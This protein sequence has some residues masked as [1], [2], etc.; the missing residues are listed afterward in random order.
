[1]KPGFPL[2]CR[3]LRTYFVNSRIGDDALVKNEGSR[4]GQIRCSVCDSFFMADTTPQKGLKEEL[5]QAIKEMDAR[6]ASF[7]EAEVFDKLRSVLGNKQ[8]S[9]EE[10]AVYQGE[11]DAFIFSPRR[12]DDA[13][14]PGYFQPLMWVP[15][16]DGSTI[17]SPDPAKLTSSTLALWPEHLQTCAH[18]VLRARY[19]DLLWEFQKQVDGIKPPLQ[20]AQTAIHA[21]LAA[22]AQANAASHEVV[23]WLGRAI[24]IATSVGDQS[25]L[26]AS[27]QQAIAWVQGTEAA[28]NARSYVF[29]FEA[30]YDNKRVAGPEKTTIIA[31]LESVLTATTDQSGTKFDHATA[32]IVADLLTNHFRRANNKADE[33]RVIRAAGLATEY[34][35]SKASALFAMMWLQKLLERCRNFGMNADADR[36]QIEARRRG[37]DSGE[38]MKKQAFA[39]TIP[40]EAVAAYRD[41]LIE[42]R[43]PRELLLR[44]AL[45]NVADVE[46]ARE[47]LKESLTATPLLA[48]IGVTAINAGQFVSRAGP[49]EDD[50]EGR[51][52]IH[53]RQL[54]EMRFNLFVG[55]WQHIQEKK[56]VS[57]NDILGAL[58]VSPIFSA[59]G[60]E[61][62]GE[63]LK[64][65][66]ANDH[67]AATHI[68]LPQVEC[69]L[70]NLLG[71]LGRPTNKAVRGESGVMQERNMNEAL[72]DPAVQTVLPKNFQ[73]HLQIVFA[74]RLGFNLR[75]VVAHGLLLASQFSILT[76]LM[77]LQGLLVMSL[78]EADAGDA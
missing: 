30:I 62:I 76:S 47:T 67:L 41:W 22:A 64:R 5:A 42:P 75:N 66:F 29:L 32:V 7:S 10:F 15:T 9:K 25:R 61:L 28:Q 12:K 73:R 52:A 70:R 20:Y 38:D 14:F 2:R 53:L 51:V 26:A 34:A 57:V 65:F 50:L 3:L 24:S 33:E 31:Y 17:Y 77:S 55:G 43:E 37:M 63:G 68:L 48:R 13:P 19:A 8:V 36:V 60:L 16:S 6:S 54:I 71:L 40:E 74:S 27:L 44:W 58:S 56:P 72:G 21:Y 4:A 46:D 23:V 11:T 39:L 59:E 45:N 18:P 1:V 78:V 49:V 35:A 69:A